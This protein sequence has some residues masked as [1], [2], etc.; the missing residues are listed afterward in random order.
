MAPTPWRAFSLLLAVCQLQSLSPAVLC[1]H[2]SAG[3]GEWTPDRM[4]SGLFLCA[5][6]KL[7]GMGRLNVNEA[8]KRCVRECLNSDGPILTLETF[9]ARLKAAGWPEGDIAEV[10]KAATRILATIV[11]PEAHDSK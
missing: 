10:C 3:N 8:V 1:R 5:G 11:D 9:L 6:G 7:A 2:S 4:C